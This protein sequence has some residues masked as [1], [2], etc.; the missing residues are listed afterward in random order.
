MKILVLGVRGMIGSIVFRKL[1]DHYGV[2]NVLGTYQNDRRKPEGMLGEIEMFWVDYIDGWI[3][4]NWP[5]KVD[6]VTNCIGVINKD[7]DEF[8]PDSIANAIKINSVFPHKLAKRCMK[9]GAKLIHI[10]T[11]CVFSGDERVYDEIAYHDADD[12]Y[13]R[14]KSLGEPTDNA[15]V[16]RTSIIGEELYSKKSLLEWVKSQSG[17]SIQGYTNHLWNGMTSL[18]FAE[19]CIQ[20]IEEVLWNT[21]LFHIFSETVPKCDLVKLIAKVFDVNVNVD[22]IKHAPNVYRDLASLYDL[23]DI[24]NIPSLADQLQQLKYFRGVGLEIIQG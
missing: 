10:T 6:Y 21:G 18:K 15:M 9:E 3:W 17:Q 14:S 23:V 2:D 8:D 20:I 19:C 1:V 22:P 11:D 7:I 24:L 13:G 12:V 4:P 5:Q 16:I